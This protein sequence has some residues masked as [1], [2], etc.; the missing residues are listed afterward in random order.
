M[1]SQC[2]TPRQPSLPRMRFGAS[3]YDS[4]AGARSPMEPVEPLTLLS[5]VAT[6]PAKPN[7]V[8]AMS[9]QVS[10]QN[11]ITRENPMELEVHLY[12]PTQYALQQSLCQLR[13][14]RWAAV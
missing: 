11:C 3:E 4:D 2:V 12:V 8:N 14:L 1:P 7:V 6:Y 13:L 10:S 9:C 5:E